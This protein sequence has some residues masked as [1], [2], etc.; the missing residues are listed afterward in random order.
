MRIIKLT[1]LFLCITINAFAIIP[2]YCP[3]CQE[4]IYDYQ[5]DEIISG[6][7]ILAKDFKPAKENI[8]Q[9]QESDEMICPLCSEYFDGWNYY[10]HYNK[11]TV[12]NIVNS[13]VLLTKE[14]NEFKWMPYEITGTPYTNE[15]NDYI[16]AK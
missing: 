13:I 16:K 1:I 12:K 11:C 10:A 9:L 8:K 4:H 5:Y 15:V 6:Q 3:N 14:N 2:I 7:A